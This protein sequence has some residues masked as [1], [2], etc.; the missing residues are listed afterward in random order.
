MTRDAELSASDYVR[1]V[2]R[3]VGRESDLTAVATLCRQAQHAV[4]L[5]CHPAGREQLG[6]R[7]EDGLRQLLH[8]ATAGSD[9]QL[10]FARAYAAAARSRSAL[11]ELAGSSTAP[12]RSAASRSTP[13]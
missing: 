1:L 11:D 7:W 2:L 10:A 3:G 13:T 9:H 6:G 8:S 12:V 5:Y 4:S